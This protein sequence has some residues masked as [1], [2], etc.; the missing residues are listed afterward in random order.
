MSIS[1]SNEK[2]SAS[3][4]QSDR[5]GESV[6]VLLRL[7]ILEVKELG[8]ISGKELHVGLSEGLAKTDPPA[9]AER[10]P[11]VGVA[12]LAIRSEEER[13]LWVESLWQELVWSLPLFGVEMQA[14]EVERDSVTLLEGVLSSLGVL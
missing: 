13:T 4:L 14:M 11:A 1:N 9:T 10:S 8:Q 3:W 2:R 12:L 5:G 6:L 7:F